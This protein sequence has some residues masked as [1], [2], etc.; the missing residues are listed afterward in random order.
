MTNNFCVYLT[1]SFA[2]IAFLFVVIARV[3]YVQTVSSVV[4][5]IRRSDPDVEL[6]HDRSFLCK[7]EYVC[8]YYNRNLYVGLTV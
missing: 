2:R 5:M 7:Y 4:F 8:S 1:F 6:T 3:Q